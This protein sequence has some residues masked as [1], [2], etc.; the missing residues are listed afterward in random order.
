MATIR[1]RVWCKPLS[2]FRNLGVDA[3]LFEPDAATPVMQDDSLLPFSLPA[4]CRKKVTAAFDGSR[5]SSDAGV[6]LLAG[7]DRRLRSV[8]ALALL[9][10]D[11]RCPAHIT[12]EMAV[13]L[14]ARIFAV[15]C[16][17]PYADDLDHLRRNPALKLACG[18]LP[19]SGTAVASQPIIPRL[20]NAPDL[21]TALPAR[22]GFMT[23]FVAPATANAAHSERGPA[24]GDGACRCANTGRL[25]SRRAS[26]LGA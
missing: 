14:R 3:N 23:T 9:I 26:H 24:A 22:R 17:C 11:H 2:W 6:L 1:W 16:G 12:H 18:R 15:A 25:V 5:P 4:V 21:R 10:P 8:D 7:T 19:E 13:I 20:E